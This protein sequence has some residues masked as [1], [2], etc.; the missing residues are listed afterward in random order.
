[1]MC[2]FCRR[3]ARLISGKRRSKQI[4]RPTRPTGVSKGGR[5]EEPRSTLS[6]SLSCGPFAMSTSK[7]WSFW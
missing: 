7:R 2:A 6:L 3:S 5:I 4:V 1:M